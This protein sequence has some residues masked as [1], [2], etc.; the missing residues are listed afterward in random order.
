MTMTP[1]G[2]R[3]CRRIATPLKNKS[4]QPTR[5]ERVNS[6][7]PCQ[8]TKSPKAASGKTM[9]TGPLA[10]TAAPQLAP[11]KMA[12]TSGKEAFNGGPFV[13]GPLR[14]MLQPRTKKK[15]ESVVKK[16]SGASGVAARPPT[17]VQTHVAIASPPQR[18]TIG[19]KSS[20]PMRQVSRQVASVRRAEPMR[21]PV[22]FRPQSVNPAICTQFTSGGFS[23][24]RLPLNVGTTQ[25]WASSM[26]SEQAEFL[27]S[28]SS[29][30]AGAPSCTN[31]TKPA[32]AATIQP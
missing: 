5:C 14:F 8:Q 32:A 18:P 2:T 29:H 25:S 3:H 30:S 16:S 7:E 27:G 28:S 23:M 13:K 20:Q 11:I 6:V 1:V 10:S 15:S 12:D 21:A 31:S 26:A 19:P 22:S 9:P 4:C 24:R 17:A